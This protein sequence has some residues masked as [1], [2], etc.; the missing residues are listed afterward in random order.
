MDARSD[1]V[2]KLE[3]KRTNA[4]LGNFRYLAVRYDRSVPLYDGISHI[5][6]LP[7][8]PQTV[9]KQ[10]LVDCKNI[11]IVAFGPVRELAFWTSWTPHI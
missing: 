7:D 8:R 1:V 2:V 9:R 11:Q 10:L 5:A 6:L 3:I 4:W